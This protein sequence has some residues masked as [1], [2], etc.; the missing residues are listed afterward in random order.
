MQYPQNVVWYI[1]ARPW[2][3]TRQ[4]PRFAPAK[5]GTMGSAVVVELEEYDEQ[6]RPFP[7]HR[8]RKYLLT[9]G[10]VV[11]GMATNGN[12]KAGWGALL[13]EILCWQPDLG[14]SRTRKDRRLSGEYAGS[15]LLASVFEKW[16]PCEG[17]KG[18]VPENLR[19]PQN[20]WALLD[21]ESPRFQAMPAVRLWGTVNKQS[22]LHIVGYPGGAGDPETSDDAWDDGTTVESAVSKLFRQV[23]QPEPGM[24]KVEGPDETRPGMSGGG[25]FDAGNAFVG[26]HRSA[27]DSTMVR[28]AISA[29]YIRDWLLSRHLGVV[30]QQAGQPNQTLPPARREAI[31]DVALGQTPKVPFLNRAKLRGNLDFLTKTGSRFKVVSLTGNKG[32]GKTYSWHLIEYVAENFSLTPVLI[33]LSLSPTI[34]EACE[35]IANLMGLDVADLRANVLADEPSPERTGKKFA[36]WLARTTATHKSRKW[37]LVFDGLDE[38]DNPS[39]ELRDHL[40][41]WLI[42]GMKQDKNFTQV[43]LILV[44]TKVAYDSLISPYVLDEQVDALRL[45]DIEGFIETHARQLNRVLSQDELSEILQTITGGAKE[46]FNPQQMADISKQTYNIINSVLV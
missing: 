9:C 11:R 40:L 41:Q 28:G 15:R 25:I 30:L 43:V 21:V 8:I 37:W 33:D 22:V 32:S 29:D 26:V 34:A 19:I 14:Y 1:E 36:S 24:L 38:S 12:R 23:R 44:G 5:P 4:S 42:N 46:P 13:E 7:T 20:D 45:K 10:H 18:D 31:F 2:S 17:L 39:P 6:N 3:G 35:N 16:S 27:T